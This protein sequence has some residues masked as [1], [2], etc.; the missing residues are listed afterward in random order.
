MTRSE[1]WV[2][3]FCAVLCEPLED[4]QATWP[5]VDAAADQTDEALAEYDKRWAGDG[6]QREDDDDAE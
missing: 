5:S 3:M 2:R 4:N 1:V 6:E